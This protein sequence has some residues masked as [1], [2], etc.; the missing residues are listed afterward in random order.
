MN[1]LVYTL[2]LFN[3]Y[4]IIVYFFIDF[5]IAVFMASWYII[6]NTSLDPNNYQ[7]S[8]TQLVQSEIIAK[9][10]VTLITSNYYT[11]VIIKNYCRYSI[12]IYH[13]TSF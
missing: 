13:R 10:Y 9:I 8:K 4:Y 3:S 11:R 7:K 12:S 1:R 5:E 6:I 2:R